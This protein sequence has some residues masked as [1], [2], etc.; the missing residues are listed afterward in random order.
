MKTVILAVLLILGGCLVMPAQDKSSK[1][2]KPV[3]TRQMVET[4]LVGLKK[5][6]EQALADLR[7]YDGA[8][9]ESE[10]WLSQFDKAEAEKKA[11]KDEAP[12]SV[13]DKNNDGK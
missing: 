6:Q 11:K 7:A 10:Y 5:G 1:D 12:K 4:R 13:E 3:I 8:I 9:Q 2:E